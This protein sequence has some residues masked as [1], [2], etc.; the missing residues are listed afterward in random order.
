MFLHASLQTCHP[1]PALRS[2]IEPLA[3][4]ATR[5]HLRRECSDFAR[6][7]CAFGSLAGMGQGEGASLSSLQAWKIAKSKQIIR[8][9]QKNRKKYQKKT[10]SISS[11]REPSHSLPLL[12][13]HPHSIQN[14]KKILFIKF[15][16]LKS[17]TKAVHALH[18][19]YKASLQSPSPIN[20]QHRSPHYHS[21]S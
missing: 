4:G 17:Y 2:I 11:I 9:Q 20:W 6:K 1:L 15:K 14:A 19:T 18:S 21:R 16:S 3:M 10:P 12:S 8:V 7:Q 13:T 5:R